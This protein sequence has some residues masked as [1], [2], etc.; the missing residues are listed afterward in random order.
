MR[1][2]AFDV[3]G[4]GGAERLLDDGAGVGVEQAAHVDDVADGAGDEQLAFALGDRCLGAGFGGLALG[5]GVGRRHPVAQGLAGVGEVQ[6]GDDADV[7]GGG[8]G[9]ALDVALGHQADGGVDLW[10]R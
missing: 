3:G 6:R 5:G 10:R 2:D 9:E 7:L 8:G 1:R 4:L